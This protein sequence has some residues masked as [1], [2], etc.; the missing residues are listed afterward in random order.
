MAAENI[1]TVIDSLT[2]EEQEAVRQLI[3]FFKGTGKAPQSPFV[4]AV[5]E[6]I[7]QY[8]ELLKRLAQ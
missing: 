7:D 8:P 2:T 1:V 4:A 6:F 5:D 3:E